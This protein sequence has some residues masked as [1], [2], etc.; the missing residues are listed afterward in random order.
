[1]T[2]TARQRR[3]PVQERSRQTVTRILDAASE[4]IDEA[5]VEAATTRAIADRAGV[6]YPSLYRFFA[7]REEILDRLLERHVANLDALELAAEGTWQIA[8]IEDL[9]DRELDLHIAY[10]RAHPSVARL[11]FGGRSAQTVI[12]RVREHIR[13]LGERMREMLIATELIPADTDPRACLLLAELG[14]RILDLAFRD[15]PAPDPTIVELGRTALRAYVTE[16]Q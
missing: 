15:G 7:D 1:M 4:V 11:W 13:E 3:E 5:G 8:S 2:T 12:S 9:I 14:D 16:L 10:Y 6:S